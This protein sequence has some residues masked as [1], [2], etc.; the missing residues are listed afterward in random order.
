MIQTIRG[1]RVPGV[2]WARGPMAYSGVRS[3]QVREIESDASISNRG[4]MVTKAAEANVRNLRRAMTAVAAN[5]NPRAPMTI[6][7]SQSGNRFMMRR[8][9]DLPAGRAMIESVGSEPNMS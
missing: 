3:V 9:V 5:T 1:R 4:E 7:R 8:T 6:N 2:R